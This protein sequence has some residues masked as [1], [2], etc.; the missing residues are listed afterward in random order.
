MKA[1]ESTGNYPS[2]LRESANYAVKQI[3]TI[4]KS[5]GPRAPGS[6]NEKKTQEFL[7]G[8]LDKFCDSVEIEE[9]P[10]HPKA[11]LGWVRIC[12]FFIMC[13]AVLYNLGLG[14]ASLLL[15][16]LSLILVVFQFLLYKKVLDPF[17]P[18]KISRNVIGVRKPS[19]ELRRRVILSGHCDSSQEWTFSYLGG[20]KL[21]TAVIG[22]S[23][24]GI[25]LG[26]GFPILALIKGYGLSFGFD[27]YKETYLRVF[28]YI[29]YAIIPLYIVASFFENRKRTVMGANDNLTGSLASVAAARFLSENNVRFEN[30][31]VRIV[32][33]GSE[34][35]G[36][37]GS[38]A[39]CKKHEKELKET[40]TVFCGTDTLKDLDFIAV[41]NRDLTG[42]VKNDER[43]CALV[44][45]AAETTGIDL[46]YKSVYFG[47]SDAAA[48]SQAG[49]PA[50]TLAAMDPTPA[51]YYHT[52][53]DTEAI[54]E[55]KSIEAGLN[56]LLES[57]FLFDEQG[58]KT[59][60]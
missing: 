15:C 41:Y 48:V 21:L 9:F 56:I 11:F 5:I 8:E 52:R 44:K 13:S 46:P 38:K 49:I 57:V 33:T 47:A 3:K 28:G 19:G 4:C 24:G 50:A 55:P 58:L 18:K 42:T 17:Y 1:N 35:A 51:R 26:I 14:V 40:E 60:Y 36:L 25:V 37:R 54:L 30:T 32:I 2:K 59:A 29:L 53:L 27:P 7:S 39:Y 16:V 43:V 45:K 34:E 23:F 31:E 22:L 20:P 10:V 6:E 12:S